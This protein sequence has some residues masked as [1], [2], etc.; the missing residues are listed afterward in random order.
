[1]AIFGKK[2]K[3][4]VKLPTIETILQEKPVKEIKQEPQPIKQEAP[5][6]VKIE[7]YN[8]ILRSINE[9][10]SCVGAMK[11]AFVVLDRVETLK[12]EG[13]NALQE[14]IENSERKLSFLNS[15]LLKPSGYAEE[16]KAESFKAEDLEGVLSELKS[17]VDQLKAELKQAT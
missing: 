15:E 10:K 1:M 17:Q 9:L 8:Q 14:A 4:E 5:L 16:V 13:L 3:E 2:K 11:N 6:F 12:K 7:K